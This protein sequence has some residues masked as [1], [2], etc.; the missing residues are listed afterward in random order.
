MPLGL[1]GDLLLGVPFSA[2]LGSRDVV[3]ASGGGSTSISAAEDISINLANQNAGE[4]QRELSVCW[5]SIDKVGVSGCR[6][7]W[8]GPAVVGSGRHC[9]NKHL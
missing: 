7:S 8:A 1:L 4:I 5:L 9:T 2:L 3:D 6:R